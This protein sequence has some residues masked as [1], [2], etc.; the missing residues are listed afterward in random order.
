MAMVL[1]YSEARAKGVNGVS[2]YDFALDS[3]GN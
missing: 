1:S 2:V 3:L